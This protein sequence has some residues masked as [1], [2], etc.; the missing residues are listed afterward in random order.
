MK[1]LA[2]LIAIF[3]L[4][5]A[6][7]PKAHAQTSFEQAYQ[8]YLYTRSV[9]DQSFSDY[10]A[11]KNAY[12]ANMTLSLKDTARDKAFLM[13]TERD[14]LMIVYFRA[15][16]ERVAELSGLS[17]D[18]RNSVL[19]KIDNEMSWYSNHKSAYDKS[20]QLEKLFEKS[21]GAK[22]YFTTK[23]TLTVNEALF[24]ITLGEQQGLRVA[25][26]KIFKTLNDIINEQV[27]QGILTLS[28]FDNW[29]NDINSTIQILKDNESKGSNDIQKIYTQSFNASGAYNEAVNTLSLS[30]RPL[31]QLNQFLTE[32]L[33]YIKNQQ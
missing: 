24:T 9:Y 5:I 26:E 6:L 28:P 8:D 29:F 4:T 25:H 1:K 30:N 31:L 20:D 16:K 32:V 18:N 21:D 33:T 22:D 13:L 7:I 2:T 14:Q 27:E 12:L 17:E 3:I 10:Q 11:A 23:A 15:L 19:E